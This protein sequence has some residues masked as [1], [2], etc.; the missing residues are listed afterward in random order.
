MSTDSGALPEGGFPWYQPPDIVPLWRARQ[1]IQYYPYRVPKPTG[2]DTDALQVLNGMLSTEAALLALAFIACTEPPLLENKWFAVNTTQ[3]VKCWT[4]LAHAHAELNEVAVTAS[5]AVFRL[6]HT[7]WIPDTET[8]KIA[9]TL[10]RGLPRSPRGHAA[11]ERLILLIAMS[12]TN[13]TPHPKTYVWI[14]EMRRC[15]E[16][17]WNAQ[18]LQRAKSLLRQT[19]FYASHHAVSPLTRYRAANWLYETAKDPRRLLR[20]SLHG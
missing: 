1:A 2:E 14:D 16:D 13:K 10:L 18:P 17:L 4:D 5:E 19:L 8:R 9:S 7:S 11:A 6:S 12:S 15:A 3:L 20:L